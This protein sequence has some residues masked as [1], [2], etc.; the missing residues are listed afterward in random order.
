M[1]F[2]LCSN[3]YR[4][5]E[6]FTFPQAVDAVTGDAAGTGVSRRVQGPTP[7]EHRTPAANGSQGPPWGRM[8]K[9]HVKCQTRKNS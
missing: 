5:A 3:A 2:I 8:Q 4:R 9:W 7:P 1:D 6:E